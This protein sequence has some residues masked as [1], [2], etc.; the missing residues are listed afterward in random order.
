MVLQQRQQQE[1][2]TTTTTT[3]TTKTT[4]GNV[5]CE[6]CA[7]STQRN[8]PDNSSIHMHCQEIYQQVDHCMKANKGQISKCVLEW[9][10][11]R[12]CH[13]TKVAVVQQ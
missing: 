11:F 1:P 7:K 9:Q 8:V 5:V 6:N 10:K 4:K 13:E 2:T 12:Q 3:T